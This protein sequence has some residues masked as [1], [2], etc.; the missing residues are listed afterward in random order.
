MTTK[1]PRRSEAKFRIQPLDRIALA[2]ILAL[3]VAITILLFGGAHSA[4]R[5]RGFSWDGTPI[6]AE[7]IAFTVTFNR[8][9]DRD[10]VVRSL[11]IEP[12]LPGK[13]SWAGRRLAYTLDRPA[14]YGQSFKLNIGGQDRFGNVPLTPFFT[15]FRSRDRA[16][17]YIGTDGQEQGR[18]VLY[19]L[20]RDQKTLLSPSDLSVLEFK[21]YPLGDRVIFGAVPRD[22][23]DQNI[24][25]QQLYRTTTGIDGSDIAL[26]R[27]VDNR[28]YQNLKFDLSNDGKSLIVQRSDRQRLGSVG[29]W[30]IR[31][32]EAPALI[33]DKSGGRFMITP[34]SNAVAISQGQG[35]A[36]FPL[37]PDGEVLDFL[38]KFGTV[39]SFAS[40]GSA[41]A[42]IRYN[43]DY[44]RSLFWVTNQGMQK[45]ILKTKGN[46]VNAYFDPQG[47]KL[48]CL[49]TELVPGDTYREDPAFSVIDLKTAQQTPLL[50]LPSV[51]N[52]HM[53]LAPD[54]LALLFDQPQ[55]IPEGSQA[56]NA[57]RNS[58]GQAIG[59]SPLWFLPLRQINP[60]PEQLPFNGLV[61]R[62][63]P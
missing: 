4:P 35:M 60:R 41:A 3:G 53:S 24:P 42:M 46:I 15:Q 2:V 43:S 33:T 27:I 32:G 44:T 13:V 6:G 38:P 31:D 26:E 20:S 10:S 45:E 48:Y 21:P 40:D 47:D 16:F 34:D 36:F 58:E 51:R 9:M 14:P 37:T 62:W 11:K 57:P 52:I 5:V 7:D 55:A 18:L 22:N 59:S 39:L 49:L 8:P 17:L 12:D 1:T 54:G 29:L 23:P 61:P 50:K 19:N 63:L 56:L 28:D 25:E 30:L